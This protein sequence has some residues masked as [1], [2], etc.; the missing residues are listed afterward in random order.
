MG[1]GTVR[2]KGGNEE[3]WGTNFISWSL[4][5]IPYIKGLYFL[6]R[7]IAGIWWYISQLKTLRIALDVTALECKRRRARA[8]GCQLSLRYVTSVTVT[9]DVD[10]WATEIPKKSSSVSC[11]IVLWQ[12]SLFVRPF[13]RLFVRLSVALI[14]YVTMTVSGFCATQ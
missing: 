2:E 5:I 14:Y 13:V 7:K 6:F 9:E 1:E 4:V 8:Y 3:K 10:R 12:F 11:I